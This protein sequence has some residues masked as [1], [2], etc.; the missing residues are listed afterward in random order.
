[1][2]TATLS[3]L[4]GSFTIL[5]L[6]LLV[7]QNS[8][9]FLTQWGQE[10][11]VSVYLKEEADDSET[12][13][14]SKFI[15]SSGLFENV[16][17]ISKK[18]AAEK[19]KKRV[20]EYV[21]GL[22]T[23][24]DFDNPLPASF[25]MKVDG[26]LTSNNEFKKIVEF[27]KKLTQTTGVD[28]VSYGQGW[29]ENYAS[30]LRIFS[31]TS[32]VLIIVLLFGSLFVIGNSIRNSILQRRDEIEILELFG[33]TRGMII[34][35]YIFE[36]LFLGLIATVAAIFASYALYLWQADLMTSQLSFW[37]LNTKLEFL[38]AG[39]ILLTLVVGATFGGLGSY[40][41][42]RQIATGWAAAETNR[43]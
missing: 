27:A 6:A 7:H 30:V 21:P 2:Q 26:G 3:V 42:A 14:V 39:R 34:W 22:L 23:D 38:S 28:E 25:E 17:F 9:R 5:V 11:K 16:Q 12:K 20:G 40:L 8:Q 10:V 18:D 37:H 24:L 1:M 33:A 31:L 32:A 13:S 15:E 41:W 4:I 29:V 19:F 35:P 43:K 36:G